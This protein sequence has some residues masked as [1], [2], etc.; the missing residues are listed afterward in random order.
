MYK[1]VQT[2]HVNMKN[3]VIDS[4]PAGDEPTRAPTLAMV[5]ESLN[6]IYSSVE[7]SKGDRDA[8]HD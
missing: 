1:D 4:V 3:D 6:I 5:I 8:A 7:C 2:S